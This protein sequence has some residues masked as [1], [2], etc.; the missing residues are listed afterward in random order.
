MKRMLGVAITLLL[1]AGCS[2]R[3]IGTAEGWK[4]YGPPGP[5]GPMGPSGP[6]GPQGVA[7]LQGPQGPQGAM[8]DTG[9]A[10]PRG[11][12]FVYKSFPDIHFATGK[13]DLA[14][15]EMT[16]IEDVAAYLKE[17]PTFLVELEG[18]ADIRGT[19]HK[20]VRLSSRRV[21]AVR[22]ALLAAGIGKERITG[23]GYG[24]LGPKCADRTAACWEQNRRVEVL[25]LPGS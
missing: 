11:V 21:E 8:G 20:N 25:V 17:N 2:A 4:V 15:S 23:V 24:E 13:A 5:E 7:G 12:D 10:G 6:V 16:K 18:F 19:E 1:L 3:P 22:T 14:A 9:P